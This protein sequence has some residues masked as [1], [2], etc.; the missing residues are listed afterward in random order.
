MQGDISLDQ[1][2]RNLAVKN[3]YFDFFCQI[4]MTF[5]L[6]VVED[7]EKSTAVKLFQNLAVKNRCFPFLSYFDEM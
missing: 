5:V 2:F 1:L 4:L 6:M 7:A 3:C